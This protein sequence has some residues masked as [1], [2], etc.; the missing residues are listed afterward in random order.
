MRTKFGYSVIGNGKQTPPLVL[1]VLNRQTDPKMA[2]EPWKGRDS[3]KGE[4]NG[5]NRRE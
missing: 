4:S 1:L 5:N 3:S 2:L